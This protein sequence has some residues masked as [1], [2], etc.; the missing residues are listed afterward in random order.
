MVIIVLVVMVN[1]SNNRNTTLTFN[2]L[3]GPKQ[4]ECPHHAVRL[5]AQFGVLVS[6]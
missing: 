4:L 3:H 5:K 2:I 6:M 1:S